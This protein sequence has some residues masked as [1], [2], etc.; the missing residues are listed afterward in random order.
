MVGALLTGP[1]QPIEKI[2]EV[3][4]IQHGQSIAVR[5]PLAKKIT[6]SLTEEGPDQSANWLIQVKKHR[7]PGG[8]NA[9][10][11]QITIPAGQA[12]TN[13]WRMNESSI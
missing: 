8:H 6:G 12:T 1:R 2:Q 3:S 11:I 5:P 9:P 4:E 13:G 7:P 10:Q